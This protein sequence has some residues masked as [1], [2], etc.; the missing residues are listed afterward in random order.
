MRGDM[1]IGNGIMLAAALTFGVNVGD[2]LLAAVLQ[3]E[4]WQFH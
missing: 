1:N 4:R 2:A 3:S